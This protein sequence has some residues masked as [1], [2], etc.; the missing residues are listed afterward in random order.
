[1]V[2]S[3]ERLTLLVGSVCEVNT[4]RIVLYTEQ[5]AIHCP[6]S[7]EACKWCDP[8][9]FTRRAHCA[10]WALWMV[11][12]CSPGRL[13]MLAG[14][15]SVGHHSLLGCSGSRWPLPLR[16]GRLGF[17]GKRAINRSGGSR[18]KNVQ[19]LCGW[20]VSGFCRGE[21]FML[22]SYNIF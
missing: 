15:S 19:W 22:Y 4:V 7:V 6:H 1:M 8:R 14:H 2:S 3:K 18:A 20:W 12:P 16:S 10:Q 13:T 17:Y 9:P 5:H 11:P 21:W